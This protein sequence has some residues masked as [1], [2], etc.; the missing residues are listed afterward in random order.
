MI[1][2]RQC[3]EDFGVDPMVCP[4]DRVSET[5]RANDFAFFIL[6]VVA[7]SLVSRVS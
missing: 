7:V 4:V 6:G 3:E 5:G 1:V 2:D